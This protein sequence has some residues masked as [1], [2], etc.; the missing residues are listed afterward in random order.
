[1]EKHDKNIILNSLGHRI[2]RV[3]KS[4]GLSQAA[5]SYSCDMEK[6]SISKIEA[7]LVNV[8]YL[9]L[10]RLS[11]CLGIPLVELIGNY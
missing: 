1:M 3:R 7:G 8:S 11:K 4:K 10:Y 9:T 5:L 6:A 2:K